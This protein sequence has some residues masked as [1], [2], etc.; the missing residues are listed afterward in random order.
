MVCLYYTVWFYYLHAGVVG[1][2]SSEG[3]MTIPESSPP[4]THEM[5]IIK[6]ILCLQ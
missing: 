2:G 4:N 6:N 3:S 5:I 1:G